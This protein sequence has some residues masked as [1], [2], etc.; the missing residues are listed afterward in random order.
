MRRQSQRLVLLEVK[1]LAG[2]GY[3]KVALPDSTIRKIPLY[4]DQ[5]GVILH[6]ADSD[7]LITIRDDIS[8]D[9]EALL[10]VLEYLATKHLP[11]LD[12]TKPLSYTATL[13]KL[14]D[15]GLLAFK[16]QLL[17]LR[18]QICKLINMAPELDCETMLSFANYVYGGSKLGSMC[19]KGSRMGQ[20]VKQKL[21]LLLPRLSPE[22][23]SML[24]SKS[25]GPLRDQLLEVLVERLDKKGWEEESDE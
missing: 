13:Q 11:E 4:R 22:E 18:E 9:P 7:E 5:L 2:T 10:R 16:L 25:G 24:I 20:M 1:E 15:T 23:R 12:S 19:T 3:F 6:G 14:V 8:R 21:C 17:E